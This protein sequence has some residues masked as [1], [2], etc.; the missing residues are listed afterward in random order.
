V[1]DKTGQLTFK[2]LGET[3]KSFPKFKETGHSLLIRFNS[4]DEEQ[5]PTAYFKESLQH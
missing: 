2:T 1:F 4:L 3:S 5:E